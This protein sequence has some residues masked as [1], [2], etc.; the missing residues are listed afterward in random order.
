MDC[1]CNIETGVGRSCHEPCHSAM[2]R[3]PVEIIFFLIFAFE[4][5]CLS[6]HRER[7]SVVLR[8][9]RARLE[10]NGKQHWWTS[11]NLPS[12]ICCSMYFARATSAKADVV[13]RPDISTSQICESTLLILGRRT[14]S[15]DVENKQF[16]DPKVRRLLS[17]RDGQVSHVEE[18]RTIVL[19]HPASKS[20]NYCTSHKHK[21]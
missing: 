4:L 18:A 13:T 9:V 21:Y 19:S 1:R 3:G 8:C 17:E 7:I 15:L 20:M 11:Q 6:N 12:T 16:W 10:K 2:K 5:S 14:T